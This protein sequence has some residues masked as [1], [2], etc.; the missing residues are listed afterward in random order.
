MDTRVTRFVG[1]LDTRLVLETRLRP[2]RLFE[3]RL[4][5]Q[6]RLVL[7]VLR[8]SGEVDNARPIR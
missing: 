8:Y 1:L 5:F 6:T 4:L 2:Y 7:E 3:T